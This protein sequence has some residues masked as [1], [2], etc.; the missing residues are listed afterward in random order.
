MKNRFRN[1]G[2]TL[3][4]MTLAFAIVIVIIAVFAPQIRA[5]RL[6]WNSKSDNCDVIQNG[7]VFVDHFNRNVSQAQSVVAVSDSNTTSGYLEFNDPDDVTQ[8]Y[9]LSGGY[10]RFGPTGSLGDLAGP[11]DQLVFTCYDACDITV[12][13]T[14][15]NSIRLIK[16][17]ARFTNPNSMGQ[18]KT[19]TAEAYL[20]T[21]SQSE[22]INLLING[23]FEE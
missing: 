17:S 7:R 2:L 19:F 9:E 23:G 12:P 15:V 1:K 22:A 6:S 21:N 13:I 20:F 4:E 5:V 11:A 16:A 10:V 8:R 3:L 14:D 18:D